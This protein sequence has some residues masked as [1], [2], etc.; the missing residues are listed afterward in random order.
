[1]A[2]ISTFLALDTALSGVEV[3]QE[4]LDTTGSNIANVNTPDY[5]EQVVNAT[6]NFSLTTLGGSGNPIQIGTGADAQSITNQSDPYLDAAFRQ[7]NAAASSASTLEGYAQQI[8]SAIGDTSDNTIS[9]QLSQFFSDWNSLASANGDSPAGEQTVIDDAEDLANSLNS[10][11]SQLTGT[12]TGSILQQA[13]DQYND[14]LDGPTSP[15]GAGQVFTDASQIASL[16]QEIVAE[17]GNG[18]NPNTLIDQRNGFI[19]DLSSLGNVTV[20][21]NTDGSVNV[22]FGSGSASGDTASALGSST[23]TALVSGD[24]NNFDNWQTAFAGAAGSATSAASLSSSFGGTLGAL[25]GLTGYPP[26][27]GAYNS[28]TFVTASEAADGG[29]PPTGT[30]LGGTLGQVQDQLDGVANDLAQNVNNPDVEGTTTALDPPVFTTTDGSATFTGS[31][32]QVNPDLA[33]GSASLNV[34]TD[35]SIAVAEASIGSESGVTIN[36][37]FFPPTTVAG[38]GFP[39]SSF[40]TFVNFV[41][42]VAQDAQDADTTQSDL[43]TQVTNDRTSAEGVDVSQ[44]MTNLIQ[45]QQAYEASAK[46]MNTFSSMMDALMSTVGQS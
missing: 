6:E 19:D 35:S 30:F 29:T 12:G 22:Y 14:V 28:A 7:Q 31:N 18:G 1:V 24:T 44:E 4:Q 42:N 33:N 3:S 10:L 40:D 45:E 2:S 34:G 38:T 36:G 25:I 41:G 16:N 23:G 17:S 9:T 46:V 43:L 39:G 20:V 32:I 15:T 26:T 11:S 8:D 37:T 5:E 27:A 21:N 13:V